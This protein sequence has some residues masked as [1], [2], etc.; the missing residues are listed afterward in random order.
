MKI[1]RNTFGRLA[2]GQE[3]E[4]FTIKNKDMAFS[5]SNFGCAITSIFVPSKD[6]RLEDIV[7]G[8]STFDGYVTAGAYFGSFIGRFANR[9]KGG[10]F[11]LDGVDYQ[12]EKNDA[13]NNLHGG[14]RGYDKMIFEA[15]EFESVE[16]CG[17][18][19]V[20]VSPDGEQGFP[21]NVSLDVLYLL[22]E[23]NEIIMRY[24]A[25][26][27]KATPI[28]LTNHSYFNLS[29]NLHK[30]ILDH[31]VVIHADKYIPVDS[32]LI[33]IG[34]ILPV[35]NTAF[36][37][38]KAKTIGK[39]IE[40]VVGGYDHCYV[41]KD[42]GKKIM[43]AAEIFEPTSGRKMT[44]ATNQIGMQFYSGNFLDGVAGKYGQVHEKHQGFCLE[45]QVF[46]DSPNQKNFP[47]CILQPNETYESENVF[48]FSW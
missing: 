13:Q 6:G 20:R 14:F 26:A 24:K 34:E 8:Y 17:V 2:C 12:L 15:Q 23:N 11:S 31:Q 36:D 45:T 27:D 18:R 25:T 38:Q 19:F 33:P 1:S 3:V 48:G 46:P 7:L 16:G 5:V 4:L 28:N 37:F 9:I 41:I 35:A 42:G 10:L 32:D 44:L 21:G 40:K 30:S 29:G 47:S 39:D 43:S 22:T